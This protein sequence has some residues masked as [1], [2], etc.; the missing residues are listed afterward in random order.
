MITDLVWFHGVED[1]S[2]Y[3]FKAKSTGN[4]GALAPNKGNGGG[5]WKIVLS[6]YSYIGG[7]WKIKRHLWFPWRKEKLV[8]KPHGVLSIIILRGSSCCPWHGSG[9][10][11][12]LVMD[13]KS[14]PVEIYKL[15][16]LV[17][18]AISSRKN[19]KIMKNKWYEYSLSHHDIHSAYHRLKNMKVDSRK[20]G[21]FL[22]GQGLLLLFDQA[23][24]MLMVEIGAWAP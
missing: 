13:G 14:I 10:Q 8:Y 1:E 2:V 6:S 19:R 24:A 16:N 18:M 9:N 17:I 12:C 22:V 3:W 5:S 20:S 15:Q 23:M 11:N 21:F 4:P 7:T